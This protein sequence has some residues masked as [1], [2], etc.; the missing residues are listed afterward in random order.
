MQKVYTQYNIWK[1]RTTSSSSSTFCNKKKIS[2]ACPLIQLATVQQEVVG[3]R[4]VSPTRENTPESLLSSHTKQTSPE[5]DKC[6]AQR[7]GGKRESGSTFNSVLFFTYR[8]FYKK[9]YKNLK[10]YL[11][12]CFT[13]KFKF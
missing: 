3:W 11:K 2:Q 9:I 5:G 1:Q 13:R 10:S 7:P 6:T 12:K 8:Y 4:Q